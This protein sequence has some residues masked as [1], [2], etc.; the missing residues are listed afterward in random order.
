MATGGLVTGIIGTV[1]S[2]LACCC[3]G[4][5]ACLVCAGKDAINDIANNLNTTIN[6]NDINW[7]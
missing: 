1:M 3:L 7:E 4:C 5:A 2:A 6:W